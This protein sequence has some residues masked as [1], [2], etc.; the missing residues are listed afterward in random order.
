MAYHCLLCLFSHELD[1]DENP[2]SDF[3][4]DGSLLGFKHG[5]GQKYGGISNFSHRR[6]RYLQK[7][8]KR[9]SKSLDMRRQINMKNKHIFFTEESEKTGFKKSR[10]LSKVCVTFAPYLQT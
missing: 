2:D 5:S 7:N 9:K 10:T 1:L 3:D 8:M 4:N 6:V